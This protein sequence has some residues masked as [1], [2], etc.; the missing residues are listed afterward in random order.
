MALIEKKNE[1]INL[2]GKD[3][4]EAGYIQY[5]FANRPSDWFEEVYEDLKAKAN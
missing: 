3:S 1:I 4:F 5:V 2:Y